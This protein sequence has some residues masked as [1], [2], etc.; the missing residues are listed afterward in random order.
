M[1]SSSIKLLF[2]F[3]LVKSKCFFLQSRYSHKRVLLLTT[4]TK[5]SYKVIFH[6]R[7]ASPFYLAQLVDIFSY[8]LPTAVPGVNPKGLSFKTTSLVLV[9][10][11]HNLF[12]HWRTLFF[13]TTSPTTTNVKS[14]AEL[15]LN[16][17]WLEREV[18]E[19]YGFVFEGKNDTRNLLLCYG[20][21]SAPFLRSMPAIGLKELFYNITSD[22][23]SAWDVSHQI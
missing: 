4:P 6:K 17:N 23:I 14:A 1:R 5:P 22:W 13:L 18:S 12:T 7:L 2:K 16:A 3:L 15:F 20:D 10:N 11:F 21:S 9:Y 8:E 19:L